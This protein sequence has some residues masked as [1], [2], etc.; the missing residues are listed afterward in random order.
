MLPEYNKGI[1]RPIIVKAVAVMLAWYISA[2]RMMDVQMSF[3]T[4]DQAAKV[5]HP[6]EAAFHLPT[7]RVTRTHP[8]GPTAPR[9]ATG[10]P[11]KS[12]DGRFNP[13]AAQGVTQRTAVVR[14]V[15]H[16]LLGA[17]LGTSTLLRHVD[18]LQRGFG[19]RHLVGV[20]RRHIQADRQPVALRDHHHLAPLAHL[21]HPDAQA[22]FRRDETAVEKGA[23]PFQLAGLVQFI[24]NLMFDIAT[25]CSWNIVIL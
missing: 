8:N 1:H 10:A 16:Q 3:I 18:G 19:Q 15:G 7:L 13:T 2:K 21:G 24:A 23:C 6:G 14:P 22:L 17:G 11:L 25:I 12:R 20:G 5:V 9:G 4:H